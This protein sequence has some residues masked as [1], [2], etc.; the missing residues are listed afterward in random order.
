MR[1]ER[2]LFL[3]QWLP[4]VRFQIPR[5]G[6]QG[7][8]YRS[9]LWNLLVSFMDA[10]DNRNAHREPGLCI[11]SGIEGEIELWVKGSLVYS[12]LFWYDDEWQG[13]LFHDHEYKRGA[14]LSVF[15]LADGFERFLRR[16]GV[17][18]TR[19]GFRRGAEPREDVLQSKYRPR[20]RHQ[21]LVLTR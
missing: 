11:E 4:H 5:R 9:Y 14:T 2:R 1:D 12:K 13:P 21:G 15:T 6:S 18:F 3:E 19:Y 17:P 7:M 10:A 16:S 8:Q 20:K